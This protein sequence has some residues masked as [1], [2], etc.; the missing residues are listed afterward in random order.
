MVEPI[1]VVVGSDDAGY[2]YKEALKRDLEG[3]DRV[4]AVTDVGVGD[5]ETTAYPHVAV[6]A[7][8]MVA[9]ALAAG[10]AGRPAHPGSEE[11]SRH[12]PAD[13]VRRAPV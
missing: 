8:R 9:D 11:P 4:S 12:R 1:R 5:A 3:D 2:Q 6:T 7:A 13:P 10:A